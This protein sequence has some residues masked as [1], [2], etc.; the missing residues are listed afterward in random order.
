MS[1]EINPAVRLF[2]NRIYADQT[3]L[4]FLHEFLLIASAPK[5][6]HEDSDTFKSCLPRYT[7]LDECLE[8][9]ARLRYAPRARL[10]LKLFSFL[11]ASRLSSR[12][13]AH[14]EHL[15]ELRDD[16]AKKIVTEGDITVSDVLD[17]LRDLFLGLQG[18]G[19][20][21]TWCA[22]TFLPLSR[23]CL[24]GETIWNQSK[25]HNNLTWYDS[26]TS[27]STYWST[28]RH[29]FLAR[30]GE[31]FYLQLCLALSRSK[32]E[33]TDLIREAKL[34]F[35]TEEADPAQLHFK[36]EEG[37]TR[38]LDSSLQLDELAA[39]IENNDENESAYKTDLERHFGIERPHFVSTEAYPEACPKESWK[40]GY[41]FA[42][43]LSR[44]LTLKL[45]TLECIARLEMLFD[46]HILR[47]LTYLSAQRI[48]NEKLPLSLASNWLGYSF[49]TSPENCTIPRLRKLSEVSFRHTEQM[50][51]TAVHSYLPEDDDE[52]KK[53]NES[54]KY[55]NDYFKEA[56]KSHGFAVFRKI[57]KSMGFIVPRKGSGERL[58]LT[59]NI[60]R[61]LVLTLVP[62]EHDI[63]YDQFK[64]EVYQHFGIAFD[65][66]SIRL[67]MKE[68]GNA[69]DDPNYNI[70]AWVSTLLEQAAMLI[71]LSDSCSLVHNPVSL[72]T[73]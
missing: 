1:K 6:W 44:I 23:R 40:I 27:L 64:K 71:P 42:V 45:D 60:L 35:S 14:L 72:N 8:D 28:N 18:A 37:L 12:D 46:L 59:E 22:Q 15:D 43:E 17:S 51:Y 53:F 16:L 58:V 61:T 5:T 21:R 65:R 3:S 20:G 55:R 9:G 33:V 49:V 34:E 63:T 4:E 62:A 68:T 19:N 31:V 56:D 73:D 32:G 36:L 38:L 11:G 67:A 69:S 24:A 13:P 57:G 30:G 48:K 2:G 39:F 70:D 50:I 29:R 52:R 47:H 66:D 54:S 10:D 26:L 7:A 41:V 25:T